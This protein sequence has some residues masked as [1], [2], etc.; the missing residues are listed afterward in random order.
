MEQA[1]QQQI[2]K[3]AEIVEEQVDAELHRLDNMDEEEMELLRQRRLDAM[4][5]EQQQRQEWLAA[6]H[7]S[8]EE[9]PDEKAFFEQCKKSERVVVHFYR[10]S[11]F[12]CKIVDKHLQILAGK[13]LETRF[14]KINAEKS[15]FLAQRLRIVVIPTIALVM[16]GKTKDYIVGFDDLGG[17]DDFPTEMLEWR[18]GCADM[19][20]YSGNL[21]EPPVA[22]NSGG[23]KSLLGPQKK[24]TIRSGYDDDSDSDLE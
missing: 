10:D 3:A 16:G 15:P 18:L 4:K 7:G 14:L 22:G 24:K 11:A 19:I 1:L 12:R 13:H 23:K 9:L 20:K 21:S 17:T 8:Y 5:K 2:L 6:H